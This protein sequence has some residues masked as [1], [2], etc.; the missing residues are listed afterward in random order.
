VE[1][2]GLEEFYLNDNP[3]SVI[4][5]E[6]AAILAGALK[7]NTTW[8]KLHL[9]NNVIGDEGT[10]SMLD[11]FTHCNTSLMSLD[12]AGLCIRGLQAGVHVQIPT[13]P[14]AD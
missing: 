3:I 4:S 13:N 14:H 2:K 6:G 12:L 1:N 7:R 9:N 5:N 8:A 11:A 10:T